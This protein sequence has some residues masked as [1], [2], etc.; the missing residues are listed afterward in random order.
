MF[1]A[2]T[3]A[4]NN[5]SGD[6]DTLNRVGSSSITESAPNSTVPFTTM[7]G[8]SGFGCSCM[9]GVVKRIT[10]PRGTDQL[11][12]TA[13]SVSTTV[14]VAPAEGSGRGLRGAAETDGVLEGSGVDVIDALRVATTGELWLL[15]AEVGDGVKHMLGERVALRVVGLSVRVLD[16]DIDRVKVADAGTE[17]SVGDSVPEGVITTVPLND[18]MVLVAEVG[19]GVKHMLG[20]R[21]ALRVVGLSVRVCVGDIDDV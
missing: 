4:T 9:A 17:A 19:D 3:S 13:T 15:T 12:C 5:P 14:E 6:A 1:V 7:M 8:S 10:V 21:V 11:P 16:G 18:V 2:R 20:E